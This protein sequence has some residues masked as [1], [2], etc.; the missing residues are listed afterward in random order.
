MQL[1]DD[2]EWF[3]F[4]GTG[5]MD[6][7]Y[8]R[9]LLKGIKL[10]SSIKE[11]PQ[12]CFKNNINLKEI[13]LENITIFGNEC[14]YNTGIT[15]FETSDITESVGYMAFAYCRN[16][17]QLKLTEN[18]E[19][20]NTMNMYSGLNSMKEIAV[21]S[22][23][24]STCCLMTNNTGVE[25]VVFDSIEC[26]EESCFEGCTALKTVEGIEN[27]IEVGAY[28]FKDC[29]NLNNMKMEGL[30]IICEWAYSNCSNMTKVPYGNSIYRDL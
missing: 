27:V 13:N 23:I 22:F 9:T 26:I 29:N 3:S 1:N 18:V 6:I 10:N 11:I 30:E 21:P 7:D 14:L 19:Y 4:Y 5:M 12:S 2:G 8:E 15:A 24:T 16:L 28:A 25:K 17:S 20:T